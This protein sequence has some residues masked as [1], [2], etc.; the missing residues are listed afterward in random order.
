MV[1]IN[2]TISTITFNSN[3]LN[4]QI[5]RECHGGL[6]IN[7]TQAYVVCKKP[8]LNIKMHISEK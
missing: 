6:K 7:K 4:V 3:S 1:N 2:P 5:E 8:T